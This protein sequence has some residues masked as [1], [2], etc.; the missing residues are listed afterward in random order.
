MALTDM[1]DAEF[2]AAYSAAPRYDNPDVYAAE[3]GDKARPLW[4]AACLPFREFLQ[5]TGYTRAEI[6]RRYCIPL[7]TL[8]QWLAG[9][10]N[11]P[12]YVRLL[13]AEC[14][15]FLKREDL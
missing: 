5:R 3:F 4:D 2:Q 14:A 13:L 8:D 7:I 6:S 15:G 11:P 10:R 9:K 1:T 12:Q